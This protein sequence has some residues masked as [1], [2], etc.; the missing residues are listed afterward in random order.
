[1]KIILDTGATRHM[2]GNI[3]LFNTLHLQLDNN[4]IN[5]VHLADGNTTLPIHGV[6]NITINIGIHK[7]T[8]KNVLYVPQLKDTLFSVTEHIKTKDCSFMGTNNQYIL[9][10]PK[11][12][13]P[14][15]IINEV[16]LYFEKKKSI[17]NKINMNKKYHE[18][19]ENISD[20][21]SLIS[22][23]TKET[24]TTMNEVK[25]NDYLNQTTIYDTNNNIPQCIV[26]QNSTKSSYS[27][28][29][30][31]ASEDNKGININNSTIL[32]NVANK[33]VTTE[34]SVSNINDIIINDNYLISNIKCDKPINN[35]H[36]QI[37]HD[38]IIDNTNLTDIKSINNNM[39]KFHNECQQTNINT[40]NLNNKTKYPNY[41]NESTDTLHKAN[42][43]I[44]TS[45]VKLPI[46]H[47]KLYRTMNN[48]IYHTNKQKPIN[49]RN[50]DKNNNI[51]QTTTSPIIWPAEL[52]KNS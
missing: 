45:N 8:L 44:N 19:M 37:T 40:I 46:P 12:S 47:S 32:A 48:N 41:S 22:K 27:S 33:T 4:L 17:S 31:P 21:I 24:L 14:T 7:I 10:F 50:I 26:N 39:V 35:I 28:I 2:I 43:I 18:L 23:Q 42:T 9:I 1:M 15:M 36:N 16:L 29:H 3:K 52:I 30:S 38:D 20:N 5:I 51:S 13:V 6:G 34:E 25:I 11:F 49:N